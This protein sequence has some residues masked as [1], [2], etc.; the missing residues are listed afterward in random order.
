MTTWNYVFG[1][2]PVQPAQVAFAS[3]EIFADLNLEWPWAEQDTA[4]VTPV[5]LHIDPRNPNLSVIMP[6]GNQA[7]VGQPCLV[8][9]IGE[10]VV[11]VAANDGDTIITIN[12]GIAQYI[13]LTE[14]DTDGGTWA[15]V[16]FG[17]GSSAADAAALAGYGLR[18][19]SQFLDQD[20]PVIV[21]VAETEIDDTY[22]AAVVSVS[23]NVGSGDVTLP[24]LSDVGDGFFFLFSNLGT[25]AWTVEPFG[26]EL[27]DNQSVLTFNPLESAEIHA[28]A[29]GWYTI[30]RGRNT[31]F[32]FT[33]NTQ[34]VSG[35]SD[36]VLNPSQAGNFIQNFVGTL[37]GNIEVIVPNAVQPYIVK[38]ATTGAFT[39][40]VTTATGT[41][42]ICAQGET[43]WI[44]CDGT[45]VLDADTVVPTAP[46]LDMPDG[47][48]AAPGL[49][50]TLDQDTGFYRPTTNTLGISAGG[51]EIVEISPA[52]LDV[53]SGAIT[54]MGTD[55]RMLMVV[56][57]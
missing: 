25:G 17:A 46:A 48:E 50:F 1:G 38:N 3:F 8:R 7:S 39:I 51:T 57:G 4:D 10:V 12:P 44:Y 23:P 18:A 54:E 2:D 22:R 47:T 26:G 52:G 29:S 9:N 27:I 11:T 5:I 30:G 15:S 28:G 6:P 49:A 36:V 16:T 37:T 55:L 35:A 32:A 20:H 33:Q 45:D 24:Q 43:T 14:N 19:R 53:T 31:T 34:D 41:G 40:T 42:L 56:L 21:I 13:Y